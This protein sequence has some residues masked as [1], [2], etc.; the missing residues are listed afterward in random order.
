MN[1][2][3]DTYLSVWAPSWQV[4]LHAH[5]PS[6]KNKELFS[7]LYL[8]QLNNDLAQFPLLIFCA[9]NL[10]VFSLIS[11]TS[12]SIMAVFPFPPFAVC[13]CHFRRWHEL[14]W[15]TLGCWRA[16]WVHGGL[17]WCLRC[18]HLICVC[19]RCAHICFP[20]VLSIICSYLFR[21]LY[22]LISDTRNKLHQTESC[23]K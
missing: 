23:A 21:I 1:T 3:I 16:F 7:F 14:V 4:C 6:S 9:V 5:S 2:A 8:H 17:R 15:V 12:F 11:S 10:S 20:F 19:F 22:K 13:I 18:V